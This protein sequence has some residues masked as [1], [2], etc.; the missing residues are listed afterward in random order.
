MSRIDR[1]RLALGEAP[2]LFVILAAM[3]AALLA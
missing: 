2:V 3:A 1:L